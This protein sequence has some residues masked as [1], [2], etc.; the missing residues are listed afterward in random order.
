M[1]KINHKSTVNSLPWQNQLG[2]MYVGSDRYAFLVLQTQ[3]AYIIGMVLYNYEDIPSGYVEKTGEGRWLLNTDK[4]SVDHKPLFISETDIHIY[5]QHKNG[6]WYQ[7]SSRDK[8][9]VD[10]IRGAE[11]Y[12]DPDF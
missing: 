1:E 6:Y 9:P 3:G 11:P 10:F 8:S 12:R 7:I 4:M 5:K 2:T